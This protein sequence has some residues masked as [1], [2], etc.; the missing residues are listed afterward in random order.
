MKLGVIGV[1][2]RAIEAVVR[3]LI[4]CLCKVFGQFEKG[5]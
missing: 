3:V 5:W 2:E 1:L 4:L